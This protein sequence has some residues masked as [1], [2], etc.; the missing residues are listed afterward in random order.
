MNDLLSE[1]RSE[2]RKYF[3]GIIGLVVLATADFTNIIALGAQ[4]PCNV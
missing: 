3:L 1:F 4:S 2:I